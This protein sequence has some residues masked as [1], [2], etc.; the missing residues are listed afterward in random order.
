MRHSGV[1]LGALLFFAL[2]A[3]A[4][5][6]APA[7][8][9]LGSS[10]QLV[11]TSFSYTPESAPAELPAKP[12]PASPEPAM[13]QEVQ[14]IYGDYYTQ[15]FIGATYMKFFEIPANKPDL[16][17]LDVSMAYYLKPWVAADLEVFDVLGSDSGKTANLFFFGG[18]PRVRWQ[19]SSGLEFWVHGLG[20][21]AHYNP[22]TIYGYPTSGAV[23]AGGGIDFGRPHRRWV[24]RVQGDMVGTFLF[25]VHQFSPRVATGIVLKF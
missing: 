5:A 6:S 8:L 12:E 20:G 4:Q 10:V 3:G 11:P 16:G 14:G 24:Y 1:L 7:T 19:T 13:P 15:V 23:E 2:Q 17:G 9:S 21:F 22:T 25:G 18:G